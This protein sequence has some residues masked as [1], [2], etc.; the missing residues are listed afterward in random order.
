MKSYFSEHRGIKNVL[1]D[2]V[3]H[4]TIYEYIY[5]YGIKFI[6]SFYTYKWK[7]D[8]IAFE[9][10]RKSHSLHYKRGCEELI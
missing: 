9:N 4:H 3:T 10:E 8:V 2:T 1:R 5:K 6:L 7:R